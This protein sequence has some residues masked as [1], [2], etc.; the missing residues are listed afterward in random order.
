MAAPSVA[1]LEKSPSGQRPDPAINRSKETGADSIARLSRKNRK[2]PNRSG[3]LFRGYGADPSARH[4]QDNCESQ[5]K[6]EHSIDRPAH[7]PRHTPIQQS[8]DL[9]P[10]SAPVSRKPER[11]SDAP[12]K[13][14]RAAQPGHLSRNDRHSWRDYGKSR[15]PGEARS[16]IHDLE[17]QLDAMK[18]QFIY[19]ANLVHDMDSIILTSF[20]NDHHGIGMSRE[21][22]LDADIE[23]LESSALVKNKSPMN[24]ASWNVSPRSVEN[25]VALH[26][27]ALDLNI[28]RRTERTGGPADF[29]RVAQ[30]INS[31]LAPDKRTLYKRALRENL[32]YV[33]MESRAGLPNGDSVLPQGPERVK[34]SSPTSK[35]SRKDTTRSLETD[36]V[37]PGPAELSPV[38]DDSPPIPMDRTIAKQKPAVDLSIASPGEFGTP[39]QKLAHA[40]SRKLAFDKGQQQGGRIERSESEGEDSAVR[41]PLRSKEDVENE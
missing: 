17:R 1:M 27:A 23:L 32:G 37:Q 15:H 33:A 5:R 8:A 10:R 9:P 12:F 2:S 38:N 40:I 28:Q 19:L 29:Q 25:N 36:T 18:L 6:A 16:E 35:A 26:L 39:F 41:I 7:T 4:S 13:G 20:F 11:N 34:K 3:I 22:Y 31:R 24:I 21:E 30:A 14:Q